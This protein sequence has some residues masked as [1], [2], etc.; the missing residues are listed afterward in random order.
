MIKQAWAL[1]YKDFQIE[2]GKKTLFKSLIFLSVILI[3]LSSF[4]VIKNPEF[5]PVVGSLVIWLILVDILFQ[6]INRSL[7]SEDESDC[8]EALRLCPISSKV[9]FLGKF[10]YNSALVITVEI[11][12]FP[13]YI[14][15]FNLGKSAFIMLIPILL[16]SF[17]FIAIGLLISLLSLRN[18]GREL[19][20][21]IMS[22]PLFLPALFLGLRA[23]LELS[24]GASLYDI[25]DF[26]LYLFCF[27]LLAFAIAYFAFDTNMAE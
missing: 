10:I 26:L 23:S 9:I 24:V 1:A 8:W 21:N 5:K 3:F 6:S 4:V 11:V 22:L 19:L 25:L 12:T 20:T 2:S 15:F 17:G 18:Q 27:D 13:L 16:T 14:I 7:T